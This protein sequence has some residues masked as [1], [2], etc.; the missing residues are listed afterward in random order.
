MKDT[1]EKIIDLVNK[2]IPPRLIQS[3]LGCTFKEVDIIIN[4]I[5]GR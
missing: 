3:N 5:G 2:A 4:E 1:R